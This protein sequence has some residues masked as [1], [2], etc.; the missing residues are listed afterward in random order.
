VAIRKI[1]PVI[2]SGGAGSRLWPLSRTQYPK[3]LLSLKDAETMLQVTARRVSQNELFGKPLVVAGEDHRFLV[4][5]QLEAIKLNPNA[6]LL[7][8]VGRNTA[9]A[10]TIAALHLITSD[11]DALMLVM[12]SDQV[13]DN[14]TAFLEVVRMAQSQAAAGKLVTF[15]IKPDRPETGYGY[16]EIGK[17]LAKSGMSE[18]AR[19]VEKPDRKTAA[20]YVAGDK[21][22]WNGGIFLFAAKSILDALA[23]HAPDILETCTLAMQQ[24]KRDGLFIRP[25]ENLFASAPAVSIDYA[26]MEK[27][28]NVVV[29]P[30][31]MGWSDVGSWAALWEI[32]AKDKD[33]NAIT[34]DVIAVDSHNNLL[35]VAGGPAIATVGTDDLIIVSTP[36]VVMVVPRAQAQDVK[37]IVE[38]LK[39]AGREEGH[40][41]AVVHRPWGTYQTTDVGPRFQTKRIV[42]NPGA[43]LSLQMHHHRSEHWIVVTGTAKVTNG[44]EVIL[45]QENQSTYIP[46]GTQHRLENPGKVPLHLIEVQC[47]SYLGED[48]IV[49]FAD[50]YGR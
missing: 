43:Q 34:G 41:P 42:V 14:V 48:D 6:V 35:R 50:S 5:G 30:V 29:A 16:I 17:A 23:A 3:Q 45:L 9:P 12:P 25:D 44:D 1:T 40:L 2:L 7:E 15:G 37:K 22:L 38:Q 36:D 49:R 26:V 4:K 28:R 39:L 21:H 33:G 19:F 31:D 13:I 20:R 27:A 10:I 47:G 32:G 24:A 18:V 11:P 46:A 8:P